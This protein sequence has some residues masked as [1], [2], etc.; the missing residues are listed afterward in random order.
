M[1]YLI[2]DNHENEQDTRILLS[3]LLLISNEHKNHM[4]L[5]GP[6]ETIGE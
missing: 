3:K 5:C 1:M 2:D 4:A 6:K